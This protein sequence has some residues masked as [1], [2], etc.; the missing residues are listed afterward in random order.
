[1]ANLIRWDNL[2]D[3]FD[4]L[5][6][7]FFRPVVASA[8][9]SALPAKMDVVEN[10]KDYTVYADIPGVK[11]EDIR[12]EIDG[13]QVSISAETKSEREVKEGE[14]LLRAERH[15]GR[16]YRHFALGED[17]EEEGASAKY[18]NG[19]LTLTLPKKV[20]A[21]SKMLTIN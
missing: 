11:K 5:V 10:D 3:R 16:V 9:M 21:K 13:N 17:V 1:M 12:V 18:E 8:A 6:R 14:R 20:V 15:Y 7:S 2:D 4:T 19:V